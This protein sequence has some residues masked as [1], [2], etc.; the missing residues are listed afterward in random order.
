M[1]DFSKKI[2]YEFLFELELLDPETFEPS[3]VFFKIRSENSTV[4][5]KLMLEHSNINIERRIK[6]NNKIAEASYQQ[7]L[8]KAATMIA[9]WDW[10]DNDFEGQVPVYS[11]KKA[12]EIMRKQSWIYQQVMEAGRS[13][14]NFSRK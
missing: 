5:Q 9:E 12:M 3:G 1:A 6:G 8:E 13:V 7:E 14:G 2:D 11:V 4:V 10:G